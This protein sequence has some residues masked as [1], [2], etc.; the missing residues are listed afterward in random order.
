MKFPPYILAGAIVLFAAVVLHAETDS[1]PSLLPVKPASA[2]V[3]PPVPQ[4]Q[5]PVVFFRELLAMSPAERLTTLT[6]RTPEVRQRLLAKVQEYLALPPDERELRLCATELRFYLVP[7]LHQ[8][9]TNRS[10][11]LTQMPDDLKPLAKSRLALWDLLPPHLQQE[12]LDNDRTLHYFAHV[13]SSNNAAAPTDPRKDQIT[14]QFNQFFELTAREKKATLSKL[15]PVEREQMQKTLDSFEHLPPRQRITCVRSFS[16]FAGMS[17]AERTEFLKNAERWSQMSP[18][19]R[20]AWRDLVAHVPQWPPLPQSALIP[21]PPRPP[22]SE[23]S[24]N[25]NKLGADQSGS[26]DSSIPQEHAAVRLRNEQ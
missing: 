18:D 17:P 16:Q 8:P 7:L 14:D 4:A 9:P 2:R 13:E 22:K 25:G 26:M 5:S 10:A 21:P 12:F 15:S 6:N 3:M 20:Q 19:E 1:S 11:L 23:S 24:L